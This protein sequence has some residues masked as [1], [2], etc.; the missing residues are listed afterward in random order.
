MAGFI[1][2]SFSV[3]NVVSDVHSSP[4]VVMVSL[5]FNFPPLTFA[6]IVLYSAMELGSLI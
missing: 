6:F 2:Q 3:V 4:N 1:E 5:I